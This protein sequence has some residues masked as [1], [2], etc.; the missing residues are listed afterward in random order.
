M[1]INT[2]EI[3]ARIKLGT[4]MFTLV[5]LAL[6]VASLIF[7]WSKKHIFE[8]T[9]IIIYVLYLIFVFVKKYYY[10]Y[11][12]TDGPKIIIRYTSLLPLSV[13]NFS[14]EIPRRDFVKAEIKNKFGGL[15][16]ELTVYVRTPQGVAKFKPISLTTLNKKEFKA[17]EKELRLL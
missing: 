11:Y 4:M 2:K 3:S 8:I 10:I 5:I 15:R 13:G 7:G 6:I 17:M 12:N 14:I 16:K 1:V 9:L